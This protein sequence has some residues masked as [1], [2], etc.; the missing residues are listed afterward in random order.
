MDNTLEK[1]LREDGTESG[2]DTGPRE[3]AISPPSDGGARE[4]GCH[5]TEKK[6]S[7]TLYIMHNACAHACIFFLFVSVFLCC[8]FVLVVP[9][10]KTMYDSVVYYG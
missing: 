3:I 2:E 5:E 9:T 7:G 4:N 6:G 10:D 1:H 8:G